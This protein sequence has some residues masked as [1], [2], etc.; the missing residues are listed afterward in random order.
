M[1]QVAVEVALPG[2]IEPDVLAVPVAEDGAAA[3][4]KAARVLDERLNGRLRTLVESGEASGELGRTLLLHTDRE[5]RA[6]RVATAGVGKGEEVD[7]DAVRTAAAAVARASSNVG[8]TL[9][10]LIDEQL[11]LSAEEQARAVVEGVALAS[12]AP[13]RWK[14]KPEDR[15]PFERIVICCADDPAVEAAA[16]RAARISRWVNFARD[17]ANAPPNE[18]TPETLGDRAAE[19][20]SP[21]LTTDVLDPGRIDELAMGALSAVGRASRN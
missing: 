17:L 21:G 15:R 13:A 11:R 16:E 2:Q 10:W 5:L 20:S 7:S 19:L 14:T 9:G 12:Y 4:S 1:D 3:F 6:R 18:L 8:G